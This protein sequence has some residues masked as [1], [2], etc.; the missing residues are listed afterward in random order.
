VNGDGQQFVDRLERR[1]SFPLPS[2]GNAG[3]GGPD[4][5]GMVGVWLIRS[6]ISPRGGTFEEVCRHSSGSRN[7][8]ST[9]GRTDLDLPD[10]TL[11]ER[12]SSDGCPRRDE[13]SEPHVAGEVAEGS[14]LQPVRSTLL[15]SSRWQARRDHM[16]EGQRVTLGRLMLRLRVYRKPRRSPTNPRRPLLLLP[17]YRFEKASPPFNTPERIKETRMLNE[18]IEDTDLWAEIRGSQGLTI[19]GR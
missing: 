19:L 17:D 10:P 7:M 4:L 5:T 18:I 8:A 9:P 1:R 3:G 16:A 13:H 15:I 12:R 6:S 11:S 14:R 2:S